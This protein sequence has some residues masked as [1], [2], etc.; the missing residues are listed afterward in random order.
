VRF[1]V[2]PAERPGKGQVF[3]R[4]PAGGKTCPPFEAVSRERGLELCGTLVQR[5]MSQRC[6]SPAAAVVVV[7]RGTGDRRAFDHCELDAQ[8]GSTITCCRIRATVAIGGRD[9]G[10]DPGEQPR[11]VK[12]VDGIED[13][14]GI[15]GPGRN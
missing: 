13:G 6:P 1:A 14:A 11:L 7:A 4:A 12:T 5:A 10:P 8:P 3:G 15:E 2:R 9:R